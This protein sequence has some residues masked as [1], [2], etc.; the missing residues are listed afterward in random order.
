MRQD[1][2]PDGVVGIGGLGNDPEALVWV[3][4]DGDDFGACGSDGPV[5]AKEIQGII[6]IQ[7]ALEIKRQMEIK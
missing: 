7:A 4:D 6:G 3:M 1:L 2:W 5:L